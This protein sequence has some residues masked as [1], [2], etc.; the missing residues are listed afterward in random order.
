MANY[1]QLTRVGETTP[2]TFQRVDE[3]LCRYMGEAVHEVR[4]AFGWYD[5]FGLVIA[6]GKKPDQIRGYAADRDEDE[7]NLINKICEYLQTYYEWD[8]WYQAGR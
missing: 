7:R 4:W 3:E 5:F 6:Q 8:S 2:S 1:F